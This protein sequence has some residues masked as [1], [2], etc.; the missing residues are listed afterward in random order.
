MATRCGIGGACETTRTPSWFTTTRAV[1]SQAK[2]F[3]RDLAGDPQRHVVF[4][5]G[6]QRVAAALLARDGLQGGPTGGVDFGF[7]H[8]I[9]L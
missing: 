5:A 2:G 6:H 9:Q 4:G 1:A 3:V 7:V 8:T